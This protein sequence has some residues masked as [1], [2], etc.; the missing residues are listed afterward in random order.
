MSEVDSFILKFNNFQHVEV[1]HP[2]GIPRTHT[3]S[4]QADCDQANLEYVNVFTYTFSPTGNCFIFDK[5]RMKIRKSYSY[6][7]I[8]EISILTISMT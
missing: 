3:S 1:D 4:E 2:A 6:E 7:N 8:I 5:W